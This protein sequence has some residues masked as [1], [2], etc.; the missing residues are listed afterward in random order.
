MDSMERWAEIASLVD[1][2]LDAPP[3]ARDAL[4]VWYRPDYEFLELCR[5]LAL[6]R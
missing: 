5:E 4:T 2:L 3:E 1:A 6:R